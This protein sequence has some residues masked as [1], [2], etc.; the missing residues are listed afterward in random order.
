MYICNMYILKGKSWLKF[1]P[2]LKVPQLRQT[3]SPG[4]SLPPRSPSHTFTPASN[5]H[6]LAGLPESL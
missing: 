3:V 6:H 2:V 5:L 4:F 1:S